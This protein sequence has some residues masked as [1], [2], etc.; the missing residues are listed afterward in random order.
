M[1]TDRIFPNFKDFVFENNS[2]QKMM[3]GQY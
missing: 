2:F 1:K 3:F